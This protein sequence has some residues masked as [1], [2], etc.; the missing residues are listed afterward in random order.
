M[1]FITAAV[2]RFQ[3]EG[4]LKS[5]E[6]FLEVSV[7]E[8][9]EKIDLAFRGIE[10]NLASGVLAL[11]FKFLAFCSRVN[12]MGKTIKDTDLHKI[13]LELSEDASVRKRIC[14][15]IY[16]GERPT[17]L[18]EAVRQMQSAKALFEKEKKGETLTAEEKATLQDAKDLQK[19]IITVD[20]FT[21]DV[22]MPKDSKIPKA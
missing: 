21:H 15:N 17:L 11:P 1:Y 6:V 20:S 13:A 4:S 3:T 12:P 14:D 2:K 8:A 22:Y 5:D 19:E 7:E 18:L 9:F 10:V 16:L